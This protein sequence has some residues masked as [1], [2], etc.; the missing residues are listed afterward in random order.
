MKAGLKNQIENFL[1]HERKSTKGG[2]AAV[3]KEDLQDLGHIINELIA[4]KCEPDADGDYPI[5]FVLVNRRQCEPFNFLPMRYSHEYPEEALDIAILNTKI[6]NSKLDRA[7]A[8]VERIKFFNKDRGPKEV[9]HKAA[10]RSSFDKKAGWACG[11]S[12]G[13]PDDPAYQEIGS[14]YWTKVTCPKCLE[15]REE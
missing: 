1:E 2:W 10:T 5:N 11:L 14:Y 12:I 8:E 3:T 6:A 7:W 9:L 15:K 4:E 13:P